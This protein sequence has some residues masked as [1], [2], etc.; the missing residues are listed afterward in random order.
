MARYHHAAFMVPE[1]GAE[2]GD[3][4]P[5]AKPDEAFAATIAPST[6]DAPTPPLRSTH[7][8]LAVDATIAAGLPLPP[9]QTPLPEVS[10]SLYRTD[11]EIARGGMGRIVAAED[12]RL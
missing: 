2:D 7:V 11:H 1:D 6:S 8:P 5:K 10:A 12:R 3:R 4:A 9:T